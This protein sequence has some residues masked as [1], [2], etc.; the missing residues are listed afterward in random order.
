MQTQ[1][2]FVFLN[3]RL[4]KAERASVSVFDRGFMYGDGLFETVRTYHGVPFSLDA[5]LKRLGRSAATLGF[6]LPDYDWQDVVSRL[7]HRNQ[8]DQSDAAVRLTVT[9]G[10]SVPDLMPPRKPSPTTLVTARRVDPRLHDMQRRGVSV[11]LLPFGRD[12]FFAEHKLLGY[13]PAVLGKVIAAERGCTDGIHLESDGTVREATTASLFVFRGQ[14]LLTAPT[15]GILPG[16]T[17][18]LVLDLAAT[19][20]IHVLEKQV[21]RID[22]RHATEIFMTSSVAEIVP[23][24]SVD[25]RPVGTGRPGQLTRRIQRL[26]RHKVE[27]SCR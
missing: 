14:S 7:L 6:E 20:G 24:V 27:L 21:K 3:G 18:R 12:G 10:K 15:T 22:L 13:V 4:V 9:R 16:V 5:H 2:G 25:K 23:V 11:T 8:L 26:Y 17:R 19:D 1:A